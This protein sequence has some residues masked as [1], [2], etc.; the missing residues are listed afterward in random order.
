MSRKV[1]LLTVLFLGL[2]AC[3]PQALPPVN[4]AANPALI[5]AQNAPNTQEP[6]PASFN[7]KQYLDLSVKTILEDLDQGSEA[8]LQAYLD[9]GKSQPE[10]F[11]GSRNAIAAQ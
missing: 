5:Q 11:N 9:W 10:Y 7:E 3:A 6:L 2:T 1:S 4:P 8:S